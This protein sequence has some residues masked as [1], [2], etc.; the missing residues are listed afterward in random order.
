MNKM[1]VKLYNGVLDR[2]I[3][4]EPME[5][6]VIDEIGDLNPET[7]RIFDRNVNAHIQ[8][9]CVDK[10]YIDLAFR[11]YKLNS[12]VE[13]LV[14][15]AIKHHL[16]A[17]KLDTFVMFM[18]QKFPMNASY[19]KIWAKRFENNI[20]FQHADLECQRILKKLWPEKYEK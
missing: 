4:E 11:S 5:V 18:L 8:E 3:T 14:E 1:V 9:T 13:T 7:V 10:E 17:K 19:W 2:V 20:E 16:S 12:T 6:L 15:I